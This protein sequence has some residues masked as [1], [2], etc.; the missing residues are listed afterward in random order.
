MSGSTFANGL[1][2]KGLERLRGLR[3]ATTSVTTTAD[4]S[5]IRSLIPA[6]ID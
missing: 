5:S 2:S 1:V 3:M 4:S 6:R